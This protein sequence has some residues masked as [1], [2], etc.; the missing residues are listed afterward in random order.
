ML[1]G[2]VPPAWALIMQS[3]VLGLVL[4]VGILCAGAARGADTA[5][6][7][8]HAEKGG[9]FDLELRGR[10][11]G[12][13]AGEARWLRWADLRALPTTRM[14]VVGEFVPGKQAVTGVFLE[15]L[16]ARLPTEEGVDVVLAECTDGYAGVF[17]REFIARWRPFLVL[18]IN[19]AGPERW[20]PAGLDYNPGPYV[21]S[22]SDAAAPGVEALLDVSHKRPWGVN[23]IRLEKSVEALAGLD[24]GGR[25]ADALSERALR[26]REL[27]VNSCYS[28]HVG[29]DEKTGGTKAGRP[30]AVLEAYARHNA[31]YFKKYVREPK[32]LNP[33]AKMAAH[34]EYSD[35]EL[36]ELLAY[37]R[38][39]RKGGGGGSGGRGR[40]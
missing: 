22:V 12:V 5:P 38:A 29:P 28:C 10:L 4:G 27:W 21:I 40:E 2:L 35:A 24:A 33:G 19:G 20:P 17:T 26:G 15:D 18:E 37:V 36:A 8:W 30:F 31:S 16:L 13:P 7:R 14:E 39:E 3:W 23:V 6:L 32:A 1:A 11:A 34:P 25:E 9:E